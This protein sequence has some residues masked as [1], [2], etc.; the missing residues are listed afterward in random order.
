MIILKS[1]REIEVMRRAG[2]IVAG[3]LRSVEENLAPGIATSELDRIAEEYIIKCG[4]IPAFRGYGGFPANICVSL[5]NQVIH[6]I[7]GKRIIEEGDI[8]GVDIGVIFGEYYADAAK[9][10]PSGKISETARDL[11]L[12]AEGSF[13][14]GIK[15]ACPGYRLSDVSC[16][17]QAHAE[18]KGF[19]VVKKYVGHGIGMAMH[20]DPPVPNYGLPGRG[21]RLRKGMTLAIEPMINEKGDGVKLLDDGWTVVTEDGGLSA[22]FEHTIAIS[23]NGP[24]ILTFEE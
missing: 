21:I 2:R 23:D 5:N 10:F 24:I 15:F 4:A 1:E 13:F 14:E 18:K 7:P 9:T 22:H 19:S 16:A 3:A 6:G 8:V 12:T 11:I 20:E 17:I